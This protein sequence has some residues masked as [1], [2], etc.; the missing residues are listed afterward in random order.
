MSG[1]PNS[2]WKI[3]MIAK[4]GSEEALKQW[5]REVGARGGR[6]GTGHTFAHG[7]ADPSACGAKGG[8]ISRRRPRKVL[9]N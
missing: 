5:Q 7:K 2:K 4:L 6:N 8:T 9:A 3:S 1:K